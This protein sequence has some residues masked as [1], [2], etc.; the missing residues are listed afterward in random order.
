MKLLNRKHQINAHLKHVIRCFTDL[1]TVAMALSEIDDKSRVKP[2]V[3]NDGLY[4]VAEE[5]M[6]KVTHFTSYSNGIYIARMMPLPAQLKRFG[7]VIIK[8]SFSS[9]QSGTSVVTTLETEKTP[10]LL[11]RFF[12]RLIVSVL[13][14]QS[15]SEEKKYIQWIEQKASGWRRL[16][17]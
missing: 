10:N 6:I 11:W 15:R 4:L 8:C 16:Q 7:D 5:P 13:V 9:T 2:L 3:K 17:A 1:D 14:F 12:I